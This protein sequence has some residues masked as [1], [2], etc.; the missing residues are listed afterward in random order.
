MDKII[1]IDNKEYKMKSSAYTQFAYKDKTGRSFLSDI[2]ELIKITDSSKEEIEFG[3]LD[4][5]SELILPI[6]YV[7]IIEA[8]PSQ[9]SDYVSFLKGIENLYDDLEWVTKVIE[10][11]CTPI[12]RQ[13][14][15]N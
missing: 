13:L 2:Q 8:D 1:K 5:I 3:D 10:L 4:K 12:S 9:V 11:G 15:N 7:M 14:Q 6:A